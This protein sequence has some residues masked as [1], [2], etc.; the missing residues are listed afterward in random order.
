MMKVIVC[1]RQDHNLEME[2]AV[3]GPIL[4]FLQ[5]LRMVTG[6]RLVIYRC[7]TYVTKLL[8]LLMM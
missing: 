5:F 6:H 4:H 2:A 8:K 7:A 1:R 3:A